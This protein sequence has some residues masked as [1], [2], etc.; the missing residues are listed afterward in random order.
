MKRSRKFL[1]QW[2]LNEKCNLSCSHCYQE[3][4]SGFDF[5]KSKIF[6]IFDQFKLLLEKEFSFNP[7]AGDFAHINLTGGEPIVYDSFFEIVLEI[8]KN[9]DWLKFGLLTNGTL[10]DD[11]IAVF[12]KKAGVAFVQVSIDG[13]ETVHDGIRGAGAFKSAI[14]GLEKLSEHGIFTM[15]SFTAN[16]SNYREFPR[17]VEV[18]KKIG[19]KKVW[20]DRMVPMGQ[21]AS[22][23]FQTLS[24]LETSDFFDI[25]RSEK[26]R[27]EKSF[28]SQTFVSMHRA[29]QFHYGGLPP[30]SCSAVR[31]LL[32]LMPDGTVFPCRRYP[33]PM[34][35][36]FT[37]NLYELR[38]SW[39]NQIEPRKEDIEATPCGVC[40][41]Y[42]FC[43]GGARCISFAISKKAFSPDPGCW[44]ANPKME[45]KHVL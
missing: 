30:Y 31:E 3:N 25:M 21:G 6:Y 29:L 7:T 40:R 22:S 28:F 8:A 4:Q 19:V 17:V 26:R 42:K 35:N 33:I 16:S 2:H 5:P 13:G 10:I 11:S 37:T 14:S 23:N 32:A 1:F 39:L 27:L 36:I 24:S 18:A 41:F 34:G 12:L 38:N 15:I 45:E 20:A 43:K 44:I 9:K